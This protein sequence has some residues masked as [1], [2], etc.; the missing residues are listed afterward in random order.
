M[1]LVLCFYY[2]AIETLLQVIHDKYV[3]FY[4]DKGLGTLGGL[5]QQIFKKPAIRKSFVNPAPDLHFFGISL[6]CVCL[7]KHQPSV[8]K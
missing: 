6:Y 4:I 1:R 5:L 7:I 3:I 8:K 2:I